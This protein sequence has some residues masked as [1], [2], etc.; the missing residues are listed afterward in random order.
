V[1]SYEIANRYAFD[2]KRLSGRTTVKLTATADLTSFALDFL[3]PVRKVTVDD[4]PADFARSDGGHELRIT[5][6]AS[7]AA[8]TRHTVV[9]TYAGKPASYGYA[10]ERNWL[11]SSREVVTMNEPHM[12][13][14]WFPAND[15]PRDK[16]IV[17]V[18][19][20]VPTGREVISNGRL[21][22][23][24]TGKR[25]T[26]WH[27]R[28][29]EPMAPRSSRP[30]TSPSPRAGTGTCRGWSRSRSGSAP[31]TRRRACA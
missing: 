21:R 12:A 28:A 31:T 27:W 29:D 4:A 18:R 15:H 7:L 8:G 24:T 5:P 25:S 10:G 23:R 6:R 9:V 19:I 30:A 11:A 3:L 2:T 26:T 1:A 16:A 20:T 13:P 14:W 17:D 22:G